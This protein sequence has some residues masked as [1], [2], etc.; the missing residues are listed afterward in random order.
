MHRY[1]MLNP[2]FWFCSILGTYD[3]GTKLEHTKAEILL[4]PF[5]PDNLCDHLGMIR[6][7]CMPYTAVPDIQGSEQRG[8]G[9][10]ME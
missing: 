8:A 2:L 1:A 4:E 5:F 10:A 9:D 3:S 6:Q 7:R